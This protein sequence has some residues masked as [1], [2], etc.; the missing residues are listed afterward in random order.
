MKLPKQQQTQLWDAISRANLEAYS[1]VQRQL[2]CH[3]LARCKSL[4]VR[5]HMYGPPHVVLLHPADALEDEDASPA[6]V[7][8][9]LLRAMPPLLDA[10]GVLLENVEVLTHG[11]HIPLDTPL[12][13]LALNAAYLDQFVHL[14]VRVPP[15]L[16]RV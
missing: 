4:A 8:R 6:S 5:L 13:W 15:G 3:S 16:L 11:V 9:F 1:D 14:A 12:Y 2:L 10:S 7:R